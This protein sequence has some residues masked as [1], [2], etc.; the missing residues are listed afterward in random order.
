MTVTWTVTWSWLWGV[1]PAYLIGWV[2]C[3]RWIHGANDGSGIND[4]PRPAIGGL[5]ALWPVWVIIAAVYG[6]LILPTL[7]CKITKPLVARANY[8]RD[9]LPGG[10]TI[11]TS[12]P[13]WG[14]PC[15]L[16]PG[17][18]GTCAPVKHT[19]GPNQ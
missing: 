19:K 9:A 7:G 5:A 10:H 1:V 14:S 11:T 4:V 13:H 16:P 8:T 3:A 15:A 12:G 6:L 2:I 17:H 18:L